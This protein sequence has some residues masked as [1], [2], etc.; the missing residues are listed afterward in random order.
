MVA[1]VFPLG[2]V[3]SNSVTRIQPSAQVIMVILLIPEQAGKCLALY[4]LL[5]FCARTGMNGFIKNIGLI[6][7]FDKYIFKIR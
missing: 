3:R 1:A 2:G 5:I 7:S 4:I 6:F